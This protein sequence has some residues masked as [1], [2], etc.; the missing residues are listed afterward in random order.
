[1]LAS[2]PPAVGGEAPGEVF[3]T[4]ASLTEERSTAPDP[5]ETVIAHIGDSITATSYLPFDRR[6]DALLNAACLKDFPGRRIRN[7]NLEVDGEYIGEF[8]DTGRYQSAIK[9][10]LAKIDIAVI[11]YGSNDS[12]RYDAAE[13][14]KRLGALCDTPAV[15]YPGIRFVI[16]TG[17]YIHGADDANLKQYGPFWQAA[18]DL[19]AAR[20][21]P[22]ADVY[23]AFEARKDHALSIKEGDA[24]PSAAGV[25]LRAETEFAALRTLLAA[26]AKAKP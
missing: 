5:A 25:A 15:D 13:F 20:S 19:A 4:R 17:P 2:W 3:I 18:R 24:H 11:Q 23:K 10:H 26:P 16:A 8:L 22:L 12:R 6:I 1:M 14:K 7:I 21:F 9:E